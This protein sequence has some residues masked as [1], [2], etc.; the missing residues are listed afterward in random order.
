MGWGLVCN[1]GYSF[2]VWWCGEAVHKLEVQSAD[3]SALPCALLH[4]SV[5]PASQQSPSEGL[6][7]CPGRHL[8]SFPTYI[9]VFLV[10]S[11]YFPYLFS[12]KNITNAELANVEPPF[13]GRR[14]C[15]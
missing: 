1:A 12:I 3:V 10:D 5:S 14:M 4:A 15:A 7:L 2:S 13:R 9:L 11:H 8:G 6:Q